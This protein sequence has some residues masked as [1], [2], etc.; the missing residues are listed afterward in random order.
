M[1]VLFSG[2]F[3]SNCKTSEK[4]GP[5]QS[6]Q[7]RDMNGWK[8][9]CSNWQECSIPTGWPWWWSWF[10]PI[11]HD[12]VDHDGNDHNDADNDHDDD[13]M[14]MNMMMMTMTMMMMMISIMRIESTVTGSRCGPFREK[15]NFAWFQSSNDSLWKAVGMSLHYIFLVLCHNN[16]WSLKFIFFVSLIKFYTPD[17]SELRIL[18]E[19]SQCRN[20]QSEY[21]YIF[22]V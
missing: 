3:S 19:S 12:D 2:I 10:W 9:E 18:A 5:W 22:L 20:E 11:D 6:M 7:C 1:L 15:T 8:E 13:E 21:L 17:L 14:K 4:Q 16:L